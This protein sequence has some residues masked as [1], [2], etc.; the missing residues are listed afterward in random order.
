MPDARCVL[1]TNVVISAVLNPAGLPNRLVVNVFEHG[2][3]LVSEALLEELRSR[4]MRPRFDRYVSVPDRERIV[5]L[6]ARRGQ[7]FVVTSI[8]TDSLDPDDNAVLALALDGQADVIVSGDRKH[9]LPLHP[10]Q[11][12]AVLTPRDAATRFGIA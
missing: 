6:F 1:D 12:I 7:R 10:Y 4:I 3:V 2:T 5:T 9:V 8:V 11:G